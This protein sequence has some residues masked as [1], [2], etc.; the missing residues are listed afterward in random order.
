MAAHITK[1][2]LVFVWGFI[3]EVAEKPK[4]RSRAKPANG[5]AKPKRTRKPPAKKNAGEKRQLS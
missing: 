1:F 3:V 2:L 4:S 5:A